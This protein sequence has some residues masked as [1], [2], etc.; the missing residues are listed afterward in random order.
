M[1]V[2]GES[3]YRVR[4]ELKGLVDLEER[5]PKC[6]RD[7]TDRDLVAASRVCPVVRW[8]ETRFSKR[9]GGVV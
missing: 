3:L 8:H 9:E 2:C 5:V 7:Q 1:L 6:E 4:K